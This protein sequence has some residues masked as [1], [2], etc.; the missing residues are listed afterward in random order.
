MKKLFN[1]SLKSICIIF[2]LNFAILKIKNNIF[3]SHQLLP[4]CN[5]CFY[6]NWQ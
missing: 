1:I 6:F 2:V 4:V 3:T 5:Y